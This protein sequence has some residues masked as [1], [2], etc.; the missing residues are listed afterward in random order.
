VIALSRVEAYRAA[1]A[2]A[3][4][5]VHGALSEARRESA[6]PAYSASVRG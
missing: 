3:A 6:P 5:P 2:M 4:M 1:V